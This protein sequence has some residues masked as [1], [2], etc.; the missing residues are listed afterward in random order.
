MTLVSGW[1]D[2]G[3]VGLLSKNTTSVELPRRPWDVSGVHPK[4]G[5]S[6]F[7]PPSGDTNSRAKLV[8]S[9]V[10]RWAYKYK[11]QETKIGP[12]GEGKITPPARSHSGHWSVKVTV[13]VCRNKADG[14]VV[15]AYYTGHAGT[16]EP[17]REK[18]PF[19]VKLPTNI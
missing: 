17:G 6:K 15:K 4:M 13:L 19:S 14:L 8:R 12:L 5:R 1:Y 2:L 10:A 9:R 18:A 11:I 3:H 7:A 16:L